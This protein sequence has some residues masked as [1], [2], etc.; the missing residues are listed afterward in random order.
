MNSVVS[1]AWRSAVGMVLSIILIGMVITVV[2]IAAGISNKTVTAISDVSEEL[3]NYDITRLDG[4]RCC[5]ADVVNF[6]RKYFYGKTSGDGF[7]MTVVTRPEGVPGVCQ[8]T[9]TGDGFLRY[10]KD[11][12]TQYYI[13]P[14]AVFDCKVT[15]NENGLITLVSFEQNQAL[16]IG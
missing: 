13:R 2:R 4:A 9:Y 7:S 12:G 15:F 11:A 14:N 16:P 6:Y 8:N 10:M 1:E 5:G 3:A